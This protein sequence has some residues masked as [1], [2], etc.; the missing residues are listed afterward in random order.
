MQP[1]VSVPPQSE[2][3]LVSAPPVGAHEATC[4]N[5]EVGYSISYPAEWFV[6][7]QDHAAGV[8]ACALFAA[9]PFEYAPGRFPGFGASVYVT[10]WQGACLEFD[11]V[12]PTPDVLEEVS[13]D[14]L[15]AYRILFLPPGASESHS[16]LV[17][18][19]PDLGPVLGGVG[20]GSCES[21]HALSLRSD[22]HAPGDYELN[23]RVVDR[24]VATLTL[25]R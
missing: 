8:P 15:P 21:S 18:L 2:L 13:V 12:D 19:S 3:P 17:N 25:D 1:N 23:R 11:M 20:V 10:A 7:P 22:G 14:G 4:A 16:Y 9:D 5:T 24:M 6:Q